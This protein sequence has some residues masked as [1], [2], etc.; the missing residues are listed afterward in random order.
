MKRHLFC[1]AVLSLVFGVS[2]FAQGFGTIGGTVMDPSGALIPGARVTVTEVGTGLPRSVTS[3]EQGR[4]VIPSLRPADYD[5][6][7]ETPGF[8]KYTKRGMALLADQSL[9]VNITL[10]LGV[11]AESVTVESAPPQVNTSTSTLSQ[12][13][14]QSRVVDLP[15]NGRNAA[16]LTLLVPGAVA[17]PDAGADQGTTKTIPG[18]VTISTNGSRQNQLSYLL[19]GGNNL[20][21]YTNVNQ[22]FPFPDAL[23][24]FSVQTSNYSAEYGQNA[25]GVVNI[26]TKSGGNSLHGDVFEFNRN[27]IFNARNFFAAKRDALKRN[28]YGGTVGGPIV[29]DRT[30]FFAGY[31]GTRLRNLGNTTSTTIPTE[32]DINAAGA[33]IDPA[34][35]NLLKFLPQTSDPKGVVFFTR[36]DRQNFDEILGKVDHS[37]RKDDR[38]TVRY[39]YVRFH[40]DAVF[41]P[42]NILTYTD[43]S[44]IPFQNY[45]IHENHIFSP[46]LINDFH[47]S[48]A[49]EAA[50]RGPADGVPNVRDFGV[51]IPF[52]PARKAI[53]TVNVSGAFSFGDNPDAS[54]IRNNFTWS[55]DV[56]LVRKRHD[57][58]FG[59][60]IERSRVDLDNLFQQPGEFR[61]TSIANFLLGRLGGNPGFRQGNGEFKNNRNTFAGLYI[62]DDFHVSRRL[63]VNAGLRWEPSLPWREIKG[64]VEQFRLDDFY[65]AKKSTMFPNAPF[66]LF[67]PG[68]PGVPPNGTNGSLNLFS[69][70]VGFASDVFG[71][72]KTSLR[73][74][75]GIFYDSRTVGIF[76]NRFVDVTPF[77]TQLTLS[78]PPGPFSDPLCQTTPSCQAQKISNPFP[79]AFP[80][81]ANVAFPSPAL[82]VTYDPSRKWLAPVLYNWNLTIEREVIPGWLVRAAYV[83]SHSSHLK[84]SVELNPAAVGS[85][86][87]GGPPSVDDRR[88]LNNVFPAA[89]FPVKFGNIS[90]DSH[91]INSSYNGLQ[92]SLERRVTRGITI[93]GNYTWSKSIDDL[94][95]GA[96]GSGVADLGADAVSSRPWD[97]PLR[98]DFDRGPSD[99]DHTHRFVLSYVAR[100]PGLANASPAARG[101]FGGWALS[102]VVTAQTGR[103]LTPMSGLGSGSDMSQTG[104]GRDRAVIA[105]G[106][107]YG[108]GSCAASAPCVDY[109]N[110]NLFSQPGAGTFGNAGKGSLRWPGYYN[111]DMA[112]FKDFKASERYSVQ[113]RAEFF[114]IFNRVNFRDTN[115][116]SGFSNTV[117]N[118]SNLNSRTFGSLRS[119]LDPRI[120]QLALKIFF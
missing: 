111:W 46:A 18:A 15:L 70:R 10:Q 107:P 71:D 53:Q 105:P 98:H 108:S 19:D 32:A 92:L 64:R 104:L 49:R 79:A 55:D 65:A 114:N 89:L 41:D 48:F 68:D 115:N 84:E 112:F 67:F 24:E 21:E 101:T 76:N 42:S 85:I 72:G 16:A 118:V 74:G 61:F 66:G 17:T 120:G 94:P 12:V 9:T 47:F 103:P 63:T 82:A 14:E 78:S 96:N 29:K 60:T 69:P 77:S 5:V 33:S 28:Q 90:L 44:T 73:G 51:N 91:D 39:Y 54:F 22:P 59:G 95:Y 88:R 86:A 110:L 13:I 31:Q 93:L 58:H 75:A 81:P 1:T 80:P 100:L 25:G 6:S 34:S 119:A 56:S 38:L 8:S 102:G 36:P 116:G 87:K 40:K 26:V 52:Q 4:Y 27:A 62:Q 3:D 106:N 113:F 11:S 43:G 30:F 35:R 7:G 37:L 2:G 50:R 97:D 45:L 20:D 99:F 117:E 83:G 57:L 109:L 23:Q